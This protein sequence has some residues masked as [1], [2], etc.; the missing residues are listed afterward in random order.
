MSVTINLRFLRSQEDE[1]VIQDPPALLFCV[2]SYSGFPVVD[3]RDML[4]QNL[5]RHFLFL[6]VQSVPHD[7][8]YCSTLTIP[9]YMYKLG[10]I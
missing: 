1:D 2:I 8:P 6:P 7:L 3:A 4:Q 10:F 9:A 5:R